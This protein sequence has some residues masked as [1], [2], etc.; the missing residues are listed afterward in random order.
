MRG[1]MAE[2]NST[3][4]IYVIAERRDNELDVH[5]FNKSHLCILQD[6]GFGMTSSC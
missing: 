6:I 5:V 2:L 3:S 4:Q 1:V